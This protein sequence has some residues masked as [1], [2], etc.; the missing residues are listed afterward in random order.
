MKTCGRCKKQLPIEEF[1]LNRAMPDGRQG[2]CKPCRREVKADYYQRTKDRHNPKRAAWT[3]RRRERIQ[4]WILEYLLEHPCV[5]CGETDPL[6]LQFDHQ[7]DKLFDIS[8]FGIK[9]VSW[10]KLMQEIE[11][12]EVVCANDHQRRT[13]ATHGW[14]KVAALARLNGVPVSEAAQTEPSPASS[15]DRAAVS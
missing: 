9:H 12:C 11:K 10:S 15:G 5:D 14:W 6:V 1:G 3:A 8:G 4:Q 7:R 2:Y 13:A